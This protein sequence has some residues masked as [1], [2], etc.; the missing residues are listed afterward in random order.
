M[1]ASN[2]PGEVPWGTQNGELE[3]L[4]PVAHP[5]LIPVAMERAGSCTLHTHVICKVLEQRSHGS[6]LAGHSS[7]RHPSYRPIPRSSYQLLYP[8][9]SLRI[10]STSSPLPKLRYLWLEWRVSHWMKISSTCHRPHLSPCC[11]FTLQPL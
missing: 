10:F 11:R 7:S 3:G 5:G 8:P 6:F 9:Q 1:T 4:S 2:T